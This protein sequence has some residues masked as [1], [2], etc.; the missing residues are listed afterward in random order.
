MPTFVFF[1]R[2]KELERVRGA[3][4]EAIEKALAKHYKETTAFSGEGHSMLEPSTKTTTNVAASSTVESDRD[5]LEKAAQERFGKVEE[6]QTMTTLRL[7]LPDIATP[8]NIR[9]SPDQTLTDVRHLL[10]QTITLFETTPFEFMQPPAM[11]IKLED[12]SKTLSEAKLT[13]AVLTIKK[14]SI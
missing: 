11:K 1:R 7:R 3:N 9:L 6:G 14:S 4:V 13:N 8:I 12:E 2:S 5:R 10:C